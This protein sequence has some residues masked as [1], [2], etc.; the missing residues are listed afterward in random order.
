MSVFEI[1]GTDHNE[2]GKCG[3]DVPGIEFDFAFQ[4]IV[5]L[6]RKTVFAHEA[7]ARGPAESR[8]S[9]SSAR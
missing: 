2:C 7:L 3:N 8:R 6:G 5:S 1:R 4:P 9:R